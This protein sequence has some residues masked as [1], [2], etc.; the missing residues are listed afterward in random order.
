MLW[1][2]SPNGQGLVHWPKYGAG[3]EYLQ[4]QAKE[5]VVRHQLKKERFSAFTETIPEK[6][7]Q[8]S[9]LLGPLFTLRRLQFNLSKQGN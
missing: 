8:H 3:E 4:M 1:F 9:E 5:Q 7:E 6:A 2:R